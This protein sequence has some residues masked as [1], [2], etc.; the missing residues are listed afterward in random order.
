MF[1]VW[2]VMMI[3]LFVGY[4][5]AKAGENPDPY[6]REDMDAPYGLKKDGTPK[7][8]PGRKLGHKRPKPQEK[9][10]EVAKPVE[11]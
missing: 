5:Y 4:V 10:E 2:V 1:W 11:T 6:W 9:A 7:A 3:A 8:K